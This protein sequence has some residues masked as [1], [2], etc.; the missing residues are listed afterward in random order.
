MVTRLSACI[1]RP[2][3][4]NSLVDSGFDK[5]TCN[6]AAAA[7]IEKVNETKE[8]QNRQQIKLA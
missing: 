3:T 1:I 6:I 8:Q 2:N 7:N 4:P 5:R